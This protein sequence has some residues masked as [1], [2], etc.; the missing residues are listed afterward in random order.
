MGSA[1]ALIHRGRNLEN[2]GYPRDGTGPEPS[3]LSVR[4]PLVV[5][6]LTGCFVAD[7]GMTSR[8]IHPMGVFPHRRW[9]EDAPRLPAVSTANTC[10]QAPQGN[11]CVSQG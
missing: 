2:A 9:P 7:T 8:R 5:H 1:Q 10:N 11:P 6:I 3:P 4:L